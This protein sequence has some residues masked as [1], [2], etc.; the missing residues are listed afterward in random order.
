MFTCHCETRRCPPANAQSVHDQFKRSGQWSQTLAEA[1]S[2]Q[3]YERKAGIHFE[4]ETV[5][6]EMIRLNTNRTLV[7]SGGLRDPRRSCH[8]LLWQVESLVMRLTSTFWGN[9]TVA[10]SLRS[11]CT[12]GSK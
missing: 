12:M 4:D 1:A 7:T 10:S 6:V 5:D 8:W 11:C 2:N 3:T 9:P